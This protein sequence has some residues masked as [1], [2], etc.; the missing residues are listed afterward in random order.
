MPLGTAD[1][2]GQAARRRI[3]AGRLIVSDDVRPALSIQR[4]EDVVVHTLSGSMVLKSRARAMGTARE[5]ELV[6]L[7]R[8][9]SKKTFFARAGGKGV[10]VIDLQ[11]PPSP[12]LAPTGTAEAEAKGQDG[13]R[14]AKPRP[15]RRTSKP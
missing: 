9:G 13:A 12:P 3:E 5:G 10:A 6:E 15:S 14:P 7:R 2:V 4:G 8:E 1:V 11:S